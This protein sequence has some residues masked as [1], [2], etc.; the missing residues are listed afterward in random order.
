MRQMKSRDHFVYVP[1][2]WEMMLHCNVIS[3][4]LGTCITWWLEKMR[5][6]F[7]CWISVLKH[8]YDVILLSF[9]RWSSFCYRFAGDHHFVIGLPV[10]IILLSFC[11]WS[12]C[13]RFASD[14][15]FVIVLQVIDTIVE[16]HL[17]TC[18]YTSEKV[19]KAMEEYRKKCVDG[20]EPVSL[21]G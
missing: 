12:F 4:W 16:A 20:K 6:C 17:E 15:Y 21:M 11:Q 10:I 2:Q 3:Y 13:Y 18:N 9:C 1:G 7:R 8:L 14:R 5:L 19:S